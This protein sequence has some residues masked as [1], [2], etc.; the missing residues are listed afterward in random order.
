MRAA[1][2]I[3]VLMISARTIPAWTIS[4]LMIP[5]WIIMGPAATARSEPPDTNSSAAIEANAA[6]WAEL[7]AQARMTDGDYDGA[8][9][10]EQTADVNRKHAEEL[11]ARVPAHQRRNDTRPGGE[12]SP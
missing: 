12:N 8:V 6:R 9:Q 7:D 2:L 3:S 1:S 11:T 5:A 10:A 4:A